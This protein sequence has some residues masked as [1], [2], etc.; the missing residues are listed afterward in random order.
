MA[1]TGDFDFWFGDAPFLIISA[2]TGLSGDGT[3][4]PVCLESKPRGKMYWVRLRNNMEFRKTD[5]KWHTVES[6]TLVEEGLPQR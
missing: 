5:N 2:G 6:I 4:A 3:E 1:R